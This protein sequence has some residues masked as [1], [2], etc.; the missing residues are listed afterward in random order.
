MID[1][2]DPLR[3]RQIIISHPAATFD[4]TSDTGRSPRPPVSPSSDAIAPDATIIE[5]IGQGAGPQWQR[6]D[7]KNQSNDRQDQALSNSHFQALVPYSR[8]ALELR[9]GPN[10]GPKLGIRDDTNRY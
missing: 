5:R 1:T 4:S 2:Y 3:I 8:L 7:Q 9:R 6:I 10:F